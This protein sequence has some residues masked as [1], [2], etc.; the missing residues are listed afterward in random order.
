M[1]DIIT[2]EHLT[3]RYGDHL[4]VNDVSL[5]V[6]PGEIFGIIGPNGAGKTTTVE[7]MAGLRQPDEGAI[8]VL[9]LH[10]QRD[11]VKLRQRIGI[12]LQQASLPDRLRVWEAL[13]LFASF[14]ARTVPWEELLEGWGLAEKRNSAF[15]NL[16]GG[17]QQRLFIALALLNDPEVVFLD[18][19]TTGL[20]PQA[21]RATWEAIRAVRDQGKTVVLVTHFMDEAEALADRVAIIDRGRLVALNTPDNLISELEG[22]RR[23]R[24]SNRG[25]FNANSL[26]DV[27]GI[28]RIEQEGAE[29]VVHG[30]GPLLSRVAAALAAQGVEPADLRSEE[31]NLEDVFLTLTGHH[32]RS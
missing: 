31:A 16:S 18:E 22:G 11:E 14:Y 7:A 8:R 4:A 32:I 17:Q 13:D 24:F 5:R 26:T 15:G 6:Q 21:R 2:V 25:G 3:K 19:L 23:L 29:V 27:A 30:N 12:Q 20:D 1:A 10:P 9:G 28:T